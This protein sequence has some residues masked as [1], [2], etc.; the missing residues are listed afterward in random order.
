L[1]A[2]T[3]T[4]FAAL[5]RQL[6]DRQITRVYTT[7]AEGLFDF[8]TGT[9]DAPI[10]RDEKR[11][12]RFSVSALGRPARTHYRRLSAWDALGLTLLEVRLETGRTHQ[13]RVHL[14]AIGHPVVGDRVYEA[15]PASE[16]DPGRVWLHGSHLAFAHPRGGQR[17]QVDS[18]L[19][20]DLANS[21]DRLGPPN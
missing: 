16:G 19:P 11:P 5:R 14:S 9:I 13:I 4:S 8:G 3:G 12:T 7:L 2:K 15:Q 20:L 18:P 1:I 6:A 10:A 17:I 21:L